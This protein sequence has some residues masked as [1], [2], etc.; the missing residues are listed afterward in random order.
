MFDIL[1]ETLEIFVARNEQKQAIDCTSS[2]DTC[3]Q[4]QRKQ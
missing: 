1:D 2:V 3:Q 4:R